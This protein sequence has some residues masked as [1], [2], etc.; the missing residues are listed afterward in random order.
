MEL[1]S[2]I[3]IS[4]V[5]DLKQGSMSNEKNVV[6]RVVYKGMLICIGLSQMTDI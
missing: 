5:K 3:K 2:I 1:F 6:A 4:V